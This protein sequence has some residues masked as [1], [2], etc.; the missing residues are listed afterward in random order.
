MLKTVSRRL[1]VA[2]P[3]LLVM[4]FLSF[5]L[6]S[7]APG[8]YFAQ[9]KTNPQISEETIREFQQKYNLDKPLHVQYFSWLGGIARGDLG[10]SFVKKAP[11]G[12]ILLRRAWPT[13]L[14]SLVSLLIIWL[15]ALPLGIYA[16]VH[17]RKAGDRAL[18]FL[19]FLGLSLP[20]FFLA[21]LL[22][23]LVSVS[24]ILPTG[25][26]VSVG[27][28]EFAWWQKILDIAQHL[29]LPAVVIS[30]AGVA[31]L[32]RLM[33]GNMLD[34]LGE[35]YIATARAKG[36]PKRRV[37]Y[38]HAL[39][40]A[41]NPLITLFG[42]EFSG[43]LSG[44]ALTEIITSWPGMGSLMLE[45]V[46]S[47]DLYLV[48]GGMIIGGLMLIGGNLLADILLIVADPRIRAS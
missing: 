28:D 33:R 26:M 45:A 36:L 21:L 6:I 1:L 24:G 8:D 15:V 43:L 11:V 13:L 18:S 14:L 37:I 3:L 17:Y 20:N 27:F 42:F 34:I 2:V 7:L 9:L 5:S 16:A 23:Y 35:Q 40:N 38:G 25:G 44:A 31:S 32:Q 22:L 39:R 46:G 48:M 29:L 19:S 4:S 30:V 10:Y 47:Q 12:Q 41:I